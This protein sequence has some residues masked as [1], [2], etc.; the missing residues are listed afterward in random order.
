MKYPIKAGD[1]LVVATKNQIVHEVT[2][3]EVCDYG[4]YVEIPN[5]GKLSIKWS[6]I[7]SIHRPTLGSLNIGGFTPRYKVLI[8]R[9]SDDSQEAS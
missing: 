9:N 6:E 2:L 1:E 7:Q 4:L 5:F 3:L 8:W